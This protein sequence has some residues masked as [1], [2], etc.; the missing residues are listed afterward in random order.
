MQCY[1]NMTVDSN[2]ANGLH[3][4]D[5]NCAQLATNPALVHKPSRIK[6]FY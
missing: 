2:V 6:L 5:I 4:Y 3:F 1:R